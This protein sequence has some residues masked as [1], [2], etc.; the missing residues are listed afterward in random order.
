MLE[1]EI[2]GGDGGGFEAG[3]ACMDVGLGASGAALGSYF[4]EAFFPASGEEE[5]GS[6]SGEEEG[7]SAADAGRG[8]GDEGG[9][10]LEAVHVWGMVA[11]VGAGWVFGRER[12]S[13]P[14]P[15]ILRG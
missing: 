9:L 1:G 6:S 14:R 2:G 11:L 12:W 10:V 3:I 7:G 5:A 8:S 13:W 4:S 15:G